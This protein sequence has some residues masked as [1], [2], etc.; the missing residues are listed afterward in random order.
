MKV[1]KNKNGLV[2]SEKDDDFVFLREGFYCIIC[3]CTHMWVHTW[4]T[5][6]RWEDTLWVSFLSFQHVGLNDQTQVLRLGGRYLYPWAIFYGILIICTGCSQ[7]PGFKWPSYTSLPVAGI[8]S[9]HPQIWQSLGINWCNFKIVHNYDI[10][11]CESLE[12]GWK[13]E[14]MGQN[15]EHRNR[16][17]HVCP[18]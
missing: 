17:P 9:A 12:E 18:K 6:R 11:I 8:T 15:R 16:P 1:W 2:I 10:E 3:V 7:T 5:L 13:L 14:P 4:H